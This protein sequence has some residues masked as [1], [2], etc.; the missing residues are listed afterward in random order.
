MAHPTWL[1]QHIPKGEGRG[2]DEGAW[3]DVNGRR[4]RVG[5]IDIDRGWETQREKTRGRENVTEREGGRNRERERG[6]EIERDGG[7]ERNK[8][9][10]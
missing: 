7:I 5:D 3:E 10:I 6:I 2:E 4:E 1:W 8:E 9:T